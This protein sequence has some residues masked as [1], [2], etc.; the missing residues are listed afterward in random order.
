[1]IL[2]LCAA[3]GFVL[4]L[5][6]AARSALNDL[7]PMALGKLAEED[8]GPGRLLSRFLDRKPSFLLTLQ[9]GIM[10]EPG[11]LVDSIG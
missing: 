2:A 8:P 4:L 1:M 7:S 10:G 11:T 9:L 5:L 6:L 3:S